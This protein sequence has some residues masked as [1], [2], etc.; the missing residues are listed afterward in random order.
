MRRKKNEEKSDSLFSAPVDVLANTVLVM[1]LYVI[2]FLLTIGG[3]DPSLPQLFDIKMPTCISG[4]PYEYTIPSSGGIGPRKLTITRG[5]LPAN[6]NIDEYTGTIS[7]IVPVT[8]SKNNYEFTIRLDDPFGSDENSYTLK[9]TKSVLPLTAA[10]FELEFT[11]N[12]KKLK[13]G[14]IGSYY[15]E[16][17]GHTGGGGIIEWAETSL[18]ILDSVGLQLNDGRIAGTPLKY[19]E[20]DLYI[21]ASFPQGKTEFKNKNF[22]WKGSVI[23]KPFKLKILPELADQ[24]NWEFV[25]VNQN[26]R[27]ITFSDLLPDE[28]VIFERIPDGLRGTPDG[29]ITGTMKEPGTYHI[30]YRVEKNNVSLFTKT[31][32]LKVI[33]ERPTPKD[34]NITIQARLGETVQISVPHSGLTEPVR[35]IPEEA[36]Y[37]SSVQIEGERIIFKPTQ[38]TLF[39]IGLKIKGALDNTLNTKCSFVGLPA[40]ER[41]SII[42][43]DNPQFILN[44]LVRTL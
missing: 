6:L 11:N 14:R 21:E 34:E 15:E 37:P 3:E 36:N 2:F 7:G 35:L 29:V 1:F 39:D 41:L 32:E 31:K 13:T 42:F 28:T 30:Q 20:F 10:D 27:L 16:V 17:I 25:R 38:E 40:I 8:Q 22:F 23:N 12:E 18:N 9:V 44:K 43:P 4:L 19:G 5:G 33:P 26:I 24:E